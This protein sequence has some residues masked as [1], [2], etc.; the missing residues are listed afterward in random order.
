MEQLERAAQPT[1]RVQVVHIYD[2]NY[3]N[4]ITASVPKIRNSDELPTYEQAVGAK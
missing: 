1:Q 2:Q 3:N 4:N